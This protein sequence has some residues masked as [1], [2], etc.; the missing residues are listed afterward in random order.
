MAD[1]QAATT[2]SMSGLTG[3][4]VHFRAATLL[5]SK[6]PIV[7]GVDLE[8]DRG[9]MGVLVGPTGGGKTTLLRLA[10]FD[11]RPDAGSVYAAGY[12][13]D[14]VEASQ[15]PVVRR[16][17]G[18]VFQ[19]YKLLRDRSAYDNVSLALEISGMNRKLVRRRTME[20]LN[21][22]G[23]AGRRHMR[24]VFLSGGEQQRLGIARALAYDPRVLLADE[25]TG[26]LDRAA[27]EE[28]MDLIRRINHRG[29]TVLMATHN[30]EL[31]KGFGFQ[32]WYVEEG[33]VTKITP[34]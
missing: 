6:G 21:Q 8:L 20:L 12:S 28:V 30:I 23:L 27:A 15:L 18:M 24:P 19:D 11:R 3:P 26:N 33:T 4:M 25:P 31:V 2:Y 9:E 17:I 1:D 29:T 34:L 7:D 14:S 22:V 13:S 32:C 10:H 16:H 5:G